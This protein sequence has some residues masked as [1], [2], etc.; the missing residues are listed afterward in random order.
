MI[1][2]GYTEEV[3]AGPE[4]SISLN[5]EWKRRRRKQVEL[6]LY[7]SSRDPR[8][9]SWKKTTTTHCWMCYRS[10]L[11]VLLLLY[12]PSTPPPM[13]M[14]EK[15]KNIKNIFPFISTG[16]SSSSSSSSWRRIEQRERRPSDK[17]LWLCPMN[18]INRSNQLIDKIRKKKKMFLS[19]L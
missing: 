17:D 11:R 19:I 4:T 8:K 14:R 9:S 10:P 13:D 2:I 7:I 16:S 3:E 12:V 6:L 18:Y 1:A 5:S 15:K